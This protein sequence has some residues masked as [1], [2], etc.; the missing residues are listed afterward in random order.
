MVHKRGILWRSER[1][2]IF[3]KQV[4]PRNFQNGTLIGGGTL[5]P[6][7]PVSSTLLFWSVSKDF[8]IFLSLGSNFQ[9]LKIRD[10]Y[11]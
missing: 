4:Y 5:D 3:G 9:Y 8:L 1:E 7:I 11:S 10:S 6:R 2:D